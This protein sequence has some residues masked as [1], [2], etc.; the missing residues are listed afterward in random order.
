MLIGHLAL[1]LAAKRAAPRTPLGLLLMAPFLLD[2]LF[3]IFVLLGWEQ[4]RIL[5]DEQGFL[6]LELVNMPYSHSLLG[7]VG[8]A[9]LL[10][11][12]Y[13]AWRR[14]VRGAVVLALLVLSHWVLDALTHRPDMAVLLHGPKVGL[15]LWRSL[16]ATIAV[17]GSLFALCV[18]LYVSATRPIRPAGKIGLA[19]LVGL[20]V[21]VYLGFVFGPPPPSVEAVSWLTMTSWFIPLWGQ[22]IERDRALSAPG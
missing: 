13:L 6:A 16:P 4:M 22:W 12:P 8:W 11:L 15:G 20:F 14:D 2:L 10:A 19:A 5:P 18:W 7:A 17:E 9:A 3:P 21:M 1:G